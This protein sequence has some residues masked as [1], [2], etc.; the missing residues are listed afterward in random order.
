LIY[1]LGQYVPGRTFLHRMDPRLKLAAL[2]ALSLCILRTD[3]LAAA[4]ITLGL[5][6]TAFASRVPPRRILEALLPILPFLGILFLLHL[7]FTEG[8]PVWRGLPVPSREGLEKGLIVSWRFLNLIL[9]AALLTQTSSPS[10]LAQGIEWLLS[11]LRILRVP[12]QDIG[13]MICLALRFVPTLLEEYERIK[14]AQ[15]SRGLDL[16]TGSLGVRLRK[17]SGMIIPLG[18][19][20]FRRADE[21]T[22]AIEGRGY[23]HGRR[24]YLREL[25][26]SR[27]DGAALF[28]VALFVLGM[29]VIR[30]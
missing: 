13:L 1:H 24:T 4:W 2:V 10:E 26:F 9:A 17:L 6:A 8:A 15:V 29:E 19:S 22:A 28:V 12:Y 3:A 21:L 11:P 23:A 7:L 25:R 27:V 14:E 30:S 18:L 5:L 16:R 20:V